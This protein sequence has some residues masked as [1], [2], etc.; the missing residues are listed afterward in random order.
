MSLAFGEIVS[1]AIGFLV[2]VYLARTLGTAGFGKFS[3]AQAIVI[4]FV[5]L[6]NLGLD[7]YGTRQIARSPAE[8]RSLVDHLLALRVLAA[9]V[10]YSILLVL[11][12]LMPKDLVTKQLLVYMGL[13]IFVFSFNLEWFFQGMEKMQYIS[14]SRIIRAVFY[15]LFIFIWV[16]GSDDVVLVGIFFTASAFLAACLL[17][18][19]FIRQNRLPRFRIDL[20]AWQGMLKISLPMG[21]SLIMITIYHNLDSVMLGFMKSDEVVGWYN[22]AYK[23]IMIM[24][25]PATLLH[26]A[27]LPALSRIGDKDK[28]KQVANNF[29]KA[30]FLL[31]VPVGFGGVILAQPLILLVFGAEYANSVIPLQILTWNT[32]LVFINVAYG[33]PLL[34]W[35]KEKKFTL[36]VALGAAVNLVF[37]FLLIPPYG[38]I[39]ASLATVL[40]ELTV[41]I[42][43]YREFQ[44]SVSI[45]FFQSARKPFIASCVMLIGMILCQKL[46]SGFFA[47][48]FI[49]SIVYFGTMVALRGITANDFRVFLKSRL[50]GPSES[51]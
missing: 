47:L 44:K 6:I 4:Y 18:G 51:D 13:L 27:F 17:F 24:I 36:Y 2:M 42:G 16:K 7:I 25:L 37:N 23:I 31:G 15:A 19:I 1:K 34:A 3:F 45:P 39:G 35:G 28:M 12:W 5:L 10:S 40:A 21:F 32:A 20:P 11:I 14:L 30:C 41:F 8:G 43:V 26:S 22:A 9:V 29:L 46:V 49:G 50:P 48:F 38:M 33:I